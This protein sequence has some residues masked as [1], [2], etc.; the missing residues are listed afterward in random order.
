MNFASVLCHSLAQFTT[1]KYRRFE[2]PE[3]DTHQE[4]KD[5]NAMGDFEDAVMSEIESHKDQDEEVTK[6][7]SKQDKS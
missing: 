6:L 4:D 7:D 5:K 2:M 3:A 1:P